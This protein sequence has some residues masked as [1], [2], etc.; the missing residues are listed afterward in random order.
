MDALFDRL[1]DSQRATTARDL[2]LAF[3]DID[4]AEVERRLGPLGI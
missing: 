1:L 2:R 4:S 3:E